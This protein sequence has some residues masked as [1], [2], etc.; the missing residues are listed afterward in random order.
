MSISPFF[1]SCQELYT[2]DGHGT[3]YMKSLLSNIFDP[4]SVPAFL[5][6]E[7]PYILDG[8]YLSDYMSFS[9]LIIRNIEIEDVGND[10]GG[11]LYFDQTYPARM[12]SITSK[13]IMKYSDNHPSGDPDVYIFKPALDLCDFDTID[14]P[15]MDNLEIKMK[16]SINVNTK[17]IIIDSDIS[18]IKLNPGKKVNNITIKTEKIPKNF[19]NLKLDI[20]FLRFEFMKLNSLDKL[21]H[22]KSDII[23]FNKCKMDEFDWQSLIGLMTKGFSFR[24]VEIG[25]D[26]VP[27]ETFISGIEKLELIYS[28]SKIPQDIL[29]SD[30]KELVISGDMLQDESN[31]KIIKK[32]KS[33]GVK[34]ETVG[35][36][37]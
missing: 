11:G 35:L 18:D 16:K 33:N 23:S 4:N 14:T 22:I 29:K 10:Y 6:I 19:F 20:D 17:N 32:L 3:R 37:L 5:M 8:E 28:F 1:S 25:I 34:I 24:S 15:Y 7:T 2:G 27:S 12:E 9:R 13:M 36:V 30:I 21:A 31:K 26:E